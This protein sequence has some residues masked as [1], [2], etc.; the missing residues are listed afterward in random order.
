[1]TSDRPYRQALG[2]E[3]LDELTEN[4]GEQFDPRVALALVDV[5]KALH[6]L[7]PEERE[8]IINRA[9]FV[10]GRSV[11]RR[12]TSEDPPHRQSVFASLQGF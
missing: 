4:M 10:R 11:T 8:R 12:S 9:L 5:A 6:L 2:L 7:P 1:M 3:A